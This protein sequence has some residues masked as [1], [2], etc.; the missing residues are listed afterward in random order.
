VTKGAERRSLTRPAVVP[1]QAESARLQTGR[2]VSDVDYRTLP[3]QGVPTLTMSLRKPNT[4]FLRVA[5][6]KSA[7]GR[8]TRSAR[9]PATA[10]IAA[11]L[12]LGE[13]LGAGASARSSTP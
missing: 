6:A 5:Y 12:R 10:R 11:E 8:L 3:A 1:A 4:R 7:A 9:K 13:R 2:T